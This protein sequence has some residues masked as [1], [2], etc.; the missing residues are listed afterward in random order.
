MST[1]PHNVLQLPWLLA[2]YQKFH[3][4]VHSW[5]IDRLPPNLMS[6]DLP[7]SYK[8]ESAFH[9][10]IDLVVAPPCGSHSP[11]LNLVKS[12]RNNEKRRKI[13]RTYLELIKQHVLHLPELSSFP[14]G[15]V[16]QT[17]NNNFYTK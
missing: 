10:S 8:S 6:Y 4:E 16:Y 11:Y 9:W 5:G 13:I 3:S 14:E 17:L 1:D 2:D 7:E 12:G 15:N